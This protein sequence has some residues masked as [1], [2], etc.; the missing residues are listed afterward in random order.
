[1]PLGGLNQ[2]R[3]HHFRPS[4]LNSLKQE[5]NMNEGIL[6]AIGRTPLIRLKRLFSDSDVRVWAKLE[7]LNPGGSTKDRPALKIIKHGIESGA[8]KPGATIVESSSGN[9]GIGLA[10]VCAY[11]GLKF[12]CVVDSKT[13]AQNI[14]LLK[15]Y[16]AEV[17]LVSQP[18]PNTGE[19]LQA[20]LDRVHELLA[21]NPGSFWPNQ[22][23]S[24]QNSMAHHD[25]MRE[26]VTATGGNLDYV[27]CSVSTCGTIRGCA[28]Y[29]R[30]HKLHTR[31]IAVDAVGSVIYG[32]QKA[33][34]LIPGHGAAMRPKLFRADMAERCVHVSDLDCV[35]GCRLLVRQ[36]SILAGGSSGGVL[37]AL[38]NIIHELPANT[39]CALI[40]PDRGERYLD[41]IYCDEWVESHFGDVS[42]RWTKTVTTTE[43]QEEWA[44]ATATY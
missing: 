29:A 30:V 38:K 22:Y 17:D 1:M 4:T 31:I 12:I 16:G 44:T 36:E 33:K 2:A 19:Y 9:M 8:I 34:R 35:V 23:A 3:W 5:N 28:E 13:T 32:D 41:T 6:E 24:L 14:R 37:M 11:Y 40:F 39:N 43:K 42:S 10:Q 26:I 7:S 25:T 20:R 18:D 15:T 21:A 27:F